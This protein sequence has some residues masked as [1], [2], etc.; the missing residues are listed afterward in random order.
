MVAS[1]W[2]FR[3]AAAV[4]WDSLQGQENRREWGGT[5]C[6]SV[7]RTSRIAPSES[8]ASLSTYRLAENPGAGQGYLQRASGIFAKGTSPTNLPYAFQSRPFASPPAFVGAAPFSNPLRIQRTTNTQPHTISQP[9]PIIA[10]LI[11]RIARPAVDRVFIGWLLHRN[12]RHFSYAALIAASSL[13][14]SS[15]PT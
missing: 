15:P 6:S 2:P 14:S 4:S 10:R 13:W 7:K 12:A 5:I 3:L 11:P 8:G 9:N 1:R